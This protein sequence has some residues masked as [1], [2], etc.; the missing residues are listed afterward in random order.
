[1]KKI[2]F[3]SGI[4]IIILLTFVFINNNVIVDKTNVSDTDVLILVN[5][6]NKIPDNYKPELTDI[7][8]IKVDKSIANDLSGLLA[9]AKKANFPIIITTGYRTISEQKRLFDNT[10]SNFIDQGNSRNIAEERAKQMAALPGYSEHHTGLAVDFTMEGTYDEKLE[11]WAWLAANSHKY[12]FI[13]RYP[14]GK[15][16]ITSYDYEA[17]HFRYVGNHAKTIYEQGLVLEEYSNGLN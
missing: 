1:M 4:I 10:V 6:D 12:G 16:H 13:L 9:A 8:G 15:E 14:E 2:C 3:I 5:K 11:M 7:N 17:W